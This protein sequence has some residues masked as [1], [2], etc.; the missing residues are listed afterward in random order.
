MW[1]EVH[2]FLCVFF[3][4]KICLA[5][6][7]QSVTVASVFWLKESQNSAYTMKLFT[8]FICKAY[9]NEENK[10]KHKQKLTTACPKKS[11]I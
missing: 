5:L 4:F 1:Y 2:K 10:T 6:P 3:I 8:L 7:T 11:K 9:Y